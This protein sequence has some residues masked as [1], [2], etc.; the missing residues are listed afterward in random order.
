MRCYFCEMRP[1]GAFYHLENGRVVCDDCL[2]HIGLSEL[3]DALGLCLAGEFLLRFHIAT[4]HDTEAY[5]PKPR[6]DDK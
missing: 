6:R 4:R 5:I 1:A 2:S 3:M